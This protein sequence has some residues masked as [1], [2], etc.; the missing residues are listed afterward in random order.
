MAHCG[1][2]PRRQSC[3]AIRLSGRP[4]RPRIPDPP[5]W[6]IDTVGNNRIFGYQLSEDGNW[7]AFNSGG[8]QFGQQPGLHYI[9]D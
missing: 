4:A 5:G 6:A 3:K 8:A 1:S 7:F 2:A 9:C